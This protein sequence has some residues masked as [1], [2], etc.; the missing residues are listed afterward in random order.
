MSKI[1]T[2]KYKCKGCGNSIPCT[3]G[4]DQDGEQM[5]QAKDLVCLLDKDNQISC[6][7]KEVKE[8]K[9]INNRKPKSCK[10]E[11]SSTKEI[12]KIKYPIGGFAPGYYSSKCVN[13]GQEFMGD[14]YAKQ[15]E[16]CAINAINKS[17][18]Q[19][20]SELHKFKT[21]IKKFKLL[22]KF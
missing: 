3:V 19:A 14:K 17:N 20:L 8:K 18:I 7:W 10:K 5:I 12:T 6:N 16:P 2:K 1:I 13:C 9:S 21:A 15:C 11:K 4:I 22:M